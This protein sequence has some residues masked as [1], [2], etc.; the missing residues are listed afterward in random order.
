MKQKQCFKCRSVKPLVDFYKHPMMGD[1]HLG[2]CKECT[3]LDVQKNRRRNLNYYRAYDR[4]RGNRMTAEDVRR[5]R[6]RH[7]EKYKARTAVGNAIRDGRL[8][9][10]PCQECGA[11]ENVHAHHHDYSKPLDVTW[12]CSDCHWQEHAS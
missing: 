9:R 4:I 6:A 3:K 2:K 8:I 11:A 12:L 1:G 5:Q 10:Q 7:P